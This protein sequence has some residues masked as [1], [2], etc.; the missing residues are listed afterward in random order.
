M[1][2]FDHLRSCRLLLVN[3]VT[4]CTLLQMLLTEACLHY[5]Y[6]SQEGVLNITPRSGR[7]TVFFRGLKPDTHFFFSAPLVPWGDSSS[8][9]SSDDILKQGVELSSEKGFILEI[10]L[11][12]F[13]KASRRTSNSD[14]I[15]LTFPKSALDGCSLRS[16]RTSSF[17]CFQLRQYFILS[18]DV[19]WF[20]T[21]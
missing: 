21:S 4:C 13:H 18:L 7:I 10:I 2:D 5:S 11:A 16:S 8:L 14:W 6:F 17:E 20:G 19:L 1:L 15:R 3:E 9:Y 12:F